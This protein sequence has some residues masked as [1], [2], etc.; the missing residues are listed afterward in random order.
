LVTAGLL[1][2]AGAV[3]ILALV[4]LMSVAADLELCICRQW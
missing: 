4:T 3:T 2:S 1:A